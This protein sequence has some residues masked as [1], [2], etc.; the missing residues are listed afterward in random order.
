[1]VRR[2]EPTDIAWNPI[3]DT[4]TYIESGMVLTET[5][6]LT[7]QITPF[8]P[9]DTDLHNGCKPFIYCPTPTSAIT[10][11]QICFAWDNLD[12]RRNIAFRSDCYPSY[13]AD[14][15]YQ[16]TTW[17]KSSAYHIHLLCIYASARTGGD[18]R[19]TILKLTS[20]SCSKVTSPPWPTLGQLALAPG[21]QPVLPHSSLLIM[22][23]A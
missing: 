3:T 8:T 9:P 16:G 18:L 14:I 2:S 6:S 11:G 21:H 22:C 23:R 13:Y 7:P 19:P 10:P 20:T 12:S 4:I 17:S 1:M 5:I 15:F